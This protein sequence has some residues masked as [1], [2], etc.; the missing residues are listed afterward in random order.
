VLNA[1]FI[2][3]N[4]DAIIQIARSEKDPDLRNEAVQK[5]SLMSHNKAALDFMLELLK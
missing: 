3:G 1:L 4:A 5:L 2:Q